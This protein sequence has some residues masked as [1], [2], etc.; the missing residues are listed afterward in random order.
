MQTAKCEECIDEGEF[1]VC[2]TCDTITCA[3]C[4]ELSYIWDGTDEGAICIACIK[5]SK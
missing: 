3:R 1:Y 2:D 4:G 5:I